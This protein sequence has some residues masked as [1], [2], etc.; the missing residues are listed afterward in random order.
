MKRSS[1]LLRY[2]SLRFLSISLLSRDQ[3]RYVLHRSLRRRSLQV[4][5]SISIHR[6]HDGRI[7]KIDSAT[8]TSSTRQKKTRHIVRGTCNIVDLLILHHSEV[9]VV[10]SSMLVLVLVLVLMF[11]LFFFPFKLGTWYLPTYL[12]LATAAL[13]NLAP[14]STRALITI[15]FRR[16][17]K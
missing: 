17:R 6:V 3:R 4:Q 5:Q 9:R 15:T 12:L 10:L 13:F 7:D 11:F 14:N 16:G 1:P 2:R 8:T